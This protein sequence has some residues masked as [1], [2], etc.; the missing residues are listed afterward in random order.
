MFSRRKKSQPRTGQFA[1]SSFTCIPY[2]IWLNAGHRNSWPSSRQKKRLFANWFFSSLRWCP[3]SKLWRQKELVQE[4]WR[5]KLS[6]D[7]RR[8]RLIRSVRHSAD[9]NWSGR[10]L[11]FPPRRQNYISRT[12]SVLHG[13][14]LKSRS[15]QLNVERLAWWL[16][17]P[18]GRRTWEDDGDVQSRRKLV[19][20]VTNA[21][22]AS[23]ISV[24]PVSS[25][26]LLS[27]GH[28]PPPLLASSSS[29]PSPLAQVRLPLIQQSNSDG[30]K[31]ICFLL[32]YLFR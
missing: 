26:K 20:D 4:L 11:T 5:S 19:N 31:I 8:T 17:A 29:F 1:F 16:R 23:H 28:R 2:S 12:N 22:S 10:T 21:W 30:Q 15:T 7:R 9:K 18:H 27:A 25:H 6:D 3:P 14:A 24:H 32:T 13:S